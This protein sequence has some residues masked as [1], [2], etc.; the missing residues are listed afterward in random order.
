MFISDLYVS[1]Q[2]YTDKINNY[3]ILF[4]LLT[5]WNTVF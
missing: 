4:Y 1:L 5:K 2:S 3:F